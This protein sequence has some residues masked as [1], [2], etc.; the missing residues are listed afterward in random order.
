MQTEMKKISMNGYFRTEKIRF[1]KVLQQIEI[2]EVDE[3]YS[4]AVRRLTDEQ[5]IE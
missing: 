5:R 3:H 2:M 1:D 4:F